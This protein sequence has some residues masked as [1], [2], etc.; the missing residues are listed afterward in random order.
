MANI[1]VV[2]LASPTTDDDADGVPDGWEARYWSMSVYTN[3]AYDAEADIDGDTMKNWEEEVADTDPTSALSIFTV[4]DVSASAGGNATIYV[5]T[6]PGRNYQLLCNTN[7]LDA[8][9]WTN[10]GTIVA[11]DGSIMAL[12]H[13]NTTRQCYYQINVWKSE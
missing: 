6:S 4:E 11:G 10:T 9:G 13:T 2:V 1:R 5:Q 7:L 8:G 3:P 12:E